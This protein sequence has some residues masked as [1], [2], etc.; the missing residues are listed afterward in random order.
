M[1]ERA[2]SQKL[3]SRASGVTHLPLALRQPLKFTLLGR[4]DLLHLGAEG[5]A[6]GVALGSR[7]VS[8]LRAANCKSQQG[9][10][11]PPPPH[12]TSAQAWDAGS[13]M[14][15]QG[16]IS[17]QLPRLRPRCGDKVEAQRA[18]PG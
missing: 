4:Q 1:S 18:R 16:R 14:P 15:R 10:A 12:S 7:E 13:G 6:P 11:S 17:G 2:T 9:W 3:G 8:A 5:Q